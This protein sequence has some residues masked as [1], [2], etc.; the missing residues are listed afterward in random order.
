[1][2]L[3]ISKSPYC[4]CC[5]SFQTVYED[6]SKGKCLQIDGNKID[7]AIDLWKKVCESDEVLRLDD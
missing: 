2:K 4:T 6:G 5:V 7:A 1:M 3:I